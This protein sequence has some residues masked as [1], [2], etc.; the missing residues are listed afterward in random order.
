M[1]DGAALVD[2][3]TQ[4]ATVIRRR[5]EDYVDA[6]QIPL[7]HIRNVMSLPYNLPATLALY[8]LAVE[9]PDIGFLTQ[10]HDIYWECPNARNFLSP[11]RH[12]SE[13]MD[14]IMCPSLPNARH[15][16]INPLAAEALKAGRACTAPSFL[17]ASISTGTFRPSTSS[18]SAA[19][20]RCLPVIPDRC[21]PRTWSWRC[22]AGSR[23]TRRS[24]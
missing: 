7:P 14:R 20:S 17:T 22:R 8:D 9:R 3:I 12:V 13:L 15:V 21:A 5:V 23:S 2:E 18:R 24:S 4:R 10:H 16:L 6:H 11:H 19:S 1:A